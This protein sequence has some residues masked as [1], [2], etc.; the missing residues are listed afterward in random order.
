MRIKNYI[1]KRCSLQKA[2]LHFLL[3]KL[4][5]STWRKTL[6]NK[7]N[8]NGFDT[9]FGKPTNTPTTEKLLQQLQEKPEFIFENPLYSNSSPHLLDTN[10]VLNKP[11]RHSQLSTNEIIDEPLH[12]L[13]KGISSNI[14]AE[15]TS[16]SYGHIFDKPSRSSDFDISN[17]E[18]VINMN[19]SLPIQRGRS[20]SL[21]N[22]SSSQ[23]SVKFDMNSNIFH[24][25]KG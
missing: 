10:N 12:R 22:N 18:A 9:D 6:I 3:I 4:N 8:V 23:K 1:T 19:G 17:Q 16:S 2:L 15:L 25:T 24:T 11:V 21:P 5:E 14:R 13:G 7:K 20:Y